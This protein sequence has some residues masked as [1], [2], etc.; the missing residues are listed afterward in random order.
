MELYFCLL[1]VEKPVI[2]KNV[3]SVNRLLDEIKHLVRIL[4][5]QFPHGVPE[6]ESDFEHTFI[7]SRGEMLVKKRLKQLEP[8]ATDLVP[9]PEKEKWKLQLETV[10]KDLDKRLLDYNVHT[11]FFKPVYKY[12]MN[13]DKKEYRYSFNKDTPKYEW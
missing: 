12:R 7:N 13:Q 10:K 4:P 8:D 3:P 6:H 5:L 11:E 2:L 1:Q 9:D